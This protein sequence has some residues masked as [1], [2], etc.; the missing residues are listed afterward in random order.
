MLGGDIVKRS[1]RIA[2]PESVMSCQFPSSNA[3]IAAP[4]WAVWAAWATVLCTVPSCVWRLALGFGVDVGF[5]GRLGSMYT[6]TS[7]TVYVL[8]LSVASQAA[9]CLT[10]GLVKPWG[11]RVPCWVPRLGGRRI[12]PLAVVIP[13]AAGAIAVTGLC[14]AVTLVPRG[15]L[16]NPDFPHGT[17]GVIMDICYA[18]LL[19]WGPLVAALSIAYARRR[20]AGEQSDEPAHHGSE[21]R[22]P[23]LPHGARSVSC[24]AKARL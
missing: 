6:G 21:T 17:A 9:A 23:E 14:A 24:L 3:Q 20:R 2:S 15:P 5:T 1:V 12:P 10:L 11:E 18:P 22:P 7:I 8:I 13:A 16:D 4:R 19:V